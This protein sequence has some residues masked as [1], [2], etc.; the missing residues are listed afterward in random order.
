MS[1]PGQAETVRGYAN[2]RA[3]RVQSGIRKYE[4]AMLEFLG[5]MKI[6]TTPLGANPHQLA[7]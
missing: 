6:R 1:R 5:I 4:Q 7:G 3:V 2:D